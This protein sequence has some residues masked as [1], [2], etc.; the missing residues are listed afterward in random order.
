MDRN[1]KQA[2]IEEVTTLL[3]GANA[4]YVSDYRGL[5]VDQLTDLRGRLRAS[6]ATVRVLK[7]TLA[8][9][10]AE[11]AGRGELVAL[12]NGP[13]AVTFCGDDAVA[14]AKALADFAR[15][16]DQLQVRGGIL[17][18]RMLD[19]L[20]VRSL[21]TLPPREVLVARVVGGIAAPLTGLVNVLQGTI[22]G[23]VRV[24]QQVADQKAAA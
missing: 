1:Q 20:E 7:N 2:L 24:F 19:A 10:A 16:H 4:L 11:R 18:G 12:L 23:F 13:T 9:M 6:G 5:T 21:A 14:P 15:L 3:T 17:E 22:G 8:R